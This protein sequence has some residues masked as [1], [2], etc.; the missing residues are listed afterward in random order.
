VRAYIGGLAAVPLWGHR[1]GS[2]QSPSES[3]SANGDWGV[4]LSIFSAR[5]N[6]Y[7]SRISYDVSVRLSVCPSVCDVCALWSQGAIDPDTFACLDRS[8]DFATYGQRLTRIVG[9]DDAGISGGRGK[10]SSC[11]VL[12][13][14][15]LSCVVM[16]TAHVCF[17]K[18]Y[19]R[20][21][22]TDSRLCP[23]SGAAFC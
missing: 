23:R 17:L 10:G 15:R 20:V 18:E 5:C 7:I 14:A 2:R 4:N 16:L 6:I 9:W 3:E 13:T 12:A 19:C 22:V 1:H 11:A 8:D 21:S